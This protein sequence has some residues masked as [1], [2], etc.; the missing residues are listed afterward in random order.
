MSIADRTLADQLR[1][2]ILSGEFPPSSRLVELQLA[3]RYDVSR[4]AVRAAIAEL[5]K[6]GLVER[7]ANRGAT[8][9]NVSL[10]EAIQV[11]QVRNAVESLI[12][13]QAATVATADEGAE[14]LAIVQQMRD[15][16]SRG[17][18][19]GYSELN[20]RFHR[21]IREISRHTVAAEVVENLRNRAARH[22][23]RLALV[24]GR[25]DESVLQHATI[26]EAVAA[27]DAAAADAAMHAHLD[28]VI[29]VLRRWGSVIGS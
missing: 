11:T 22:N 13:A 25:P 5:D 27:G 16:I 26:A 4:A 8:V 20:G 1:D 29:D 21:R 7:E 6:E 9:R 18:H 10:A 3:E 24:P 28:S 15:A 19:L 14:L 12:A 2:G 17:D 23:F